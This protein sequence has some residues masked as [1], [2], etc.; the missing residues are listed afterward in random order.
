MKKLIGISRIGPSHIAK[1]IPNQDSYLCYKNKDFSLIIVSDGL[2]S[3]PHSE[4]GSKAACKAVLK[5]SF[6]L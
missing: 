2:G 1:K 4:I 6:D 3:K 5:A